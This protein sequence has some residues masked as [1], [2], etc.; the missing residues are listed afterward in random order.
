MAKTKITAVLTA[1]IMLVSLAG[2]ASALSGSAGNAKW[3]ITGTTLTVY[4]G[5]LPD[6]TA[7]TAPAYATFADTVTKIV[8][9]D[10]VSRIGERAFEDMTSA[11]EISFG[12]ITEI[13]R[14]AFSGCSSL[15]KITLPEG[16]TTVGSFAFAEC[17]SLESAA[18]PKSLTHLGEGVFEAS[19]ALRSITS[20]S[21]SYTVSGGILYSGDMT[22]VYRFPPAASATEI[23]LPDS[24]TTVMAGAF[25]DS[26]NLTSVVMPSVTTVEDGAFYGCS[27][28][29]S[30]SMPKA[31]Q[32]GRA[33]F[34]GCNFID[35]AFPASLNTIGD[36]AFAFC[37]RLTA[38][39]FAGDA[40]IAPDGIFYGANPTFTVIAKDTAA[41]FGTDL[42]LSYPVIRHGIY[43]GECEG[44]SWSLDSAT[45]IL[46]VT[47]E[48][49]PDFVSP[50]DA[51]WYPYR[52]LVRTIALDN[53]TGIGNN[54]FRYTA[55]RTLA[56]PDAVTRIGEYAFSGCTALTDVKIDGV[57]HIEKCAFLA[58]TA[59]D[60]VHLQSVASVGDQ[61]FSGCT[62]AYF[63]YFH[64]SSVPA[65]GE[66]AFDAI[67]GAVLYPYG[68]TGYDIADF[69]EVYVEAYA[70]GD[71]DRNGR[72]NLDDVT[73]MLKYIA[74]WNGI[75]VQKY[76]ADVN[77]DRKL[78]LADVTDMLKHIAAW[79]I[80]IGI[81]A[82]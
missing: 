49:I 11:V 63:V 13:G 39:D 56:L 10:G 58:D 81:R 72:C 28:L 8:I 3:E 32:I 52:K 59:I 33:A 19:P 42:W 43:S 29:E 41:G 64:G 14:M 53:V 62:A 30:A 61:A 27:S 35:I 78:N 44:I 37:P 20:K 16:V 60:T 21:N 75:T 26:A 22:A 80:L 50:A 45:G 76:S 34:Y 54:A 23:T 46:T 38:A 31:E 48:S 7:S 74:G 69:G 2:V 71:A 73:C 51:P 15:R 12:S 82:E 5:D 77:C 25:R 9:G 66:Y 4:G 6:Y 47:G 57:C 17:A 70:P 55:V 24:V 65:I 67:P 18:L 36:E 79:D 40:P 1:I 68:A